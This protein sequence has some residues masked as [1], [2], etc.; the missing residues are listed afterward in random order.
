MK[1]IHVVCKKRLEMVLKG[2][3]WSLLRIFRVQTLSCYFMTIF[4]S[5]KGLFWTKSSNPVKSKHYIVLQFS[6]LLFMFRVSSKENL[7]FLLIWQFNKNLNFSC[8]YPSL[9]IERWAFKI[10]LISNILCRNFLGRVMVLLKLN[11]LKKQILYSFLIGR[12]SNL[13]S[14]LHTDMTKK[15]AFKLGSSLKFMFSKKAT[16]IEK[17]LHGW[18][19]G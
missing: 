16:K 14:F 2:S 1:D 5:S 3:F 17:N 8:F 7:Q 11:V 6:M 9:K 12:H 13:V 15:E 19:D 4:I 10:M 18:F